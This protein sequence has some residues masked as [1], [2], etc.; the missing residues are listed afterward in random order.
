MVGI[1]TSIIINIYYIYIYII[2]IYIFNYKF[3]YNSVRF[4][5]TCELK[6]STAKEYPFIQLAHIQIVDF[7]ILL[8]YIYIYMIYIQKVRR[9]YFTCLIQHYYRILYIY[10]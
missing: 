6:M 1:F 3:I 2:Y 4:G 9:R 5:H 8:I 10:I 7:G